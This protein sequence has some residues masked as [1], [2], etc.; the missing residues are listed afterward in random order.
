MVIAEKKGKRARE[1]DFR[2]LVG[3]D[4]HAILFSPTSFVCGALRTPPLKIDS[5]TYD[6]LRALLV[7]IDV[8]FMR[9]S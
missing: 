5:R 4:V 2:G 7:K 1:N 9:F 3:G 6:I 8:F